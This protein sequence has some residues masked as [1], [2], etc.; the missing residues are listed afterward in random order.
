MTSTSIE[1]RERLPVDNVSLQDP[2]F[3]T[4]TCDDPD[5]NMRSKNERDESKQDV[6]VLAQ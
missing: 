1:S 6:L 4:S 3:S 5:R 2:L